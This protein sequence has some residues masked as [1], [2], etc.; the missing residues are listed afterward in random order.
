MSQ[1]R[2]QVKRRQVSAGAFVHQEPGVRRTTVSRNRT[3]ARDSQQLVVRQR[4]HRKRAAPDFEVADA[5]SKSYRVPR[6]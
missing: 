4:T 5:I 1:Q 3:S 2:P 6:S